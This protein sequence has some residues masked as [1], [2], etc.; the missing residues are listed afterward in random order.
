MAFPFFTCGGLFYWVDRYSYAG[1]RIQESIWTRRCRLLDPFNIRRGSGSLEACFDS[2]HYFLNA[3]EIDRPK[4]KAV[5]FIHGLFQRP[6]LP[7]QLVLHLL[8]LQSFL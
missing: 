4:K 2:L 7:L 6:S 1:W 3:W 8:G 5:V